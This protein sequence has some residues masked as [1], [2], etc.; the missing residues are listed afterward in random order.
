VDLTAFA[1]RALMLLLIVAAQ[2]GAAPAASA[3]N[4][5]V[6]EWLARLDELHLRRDDP[7]AR[8]EAQRVVSAAL[9]AAPADYGVLWRAARARL[10][11]S[12]LPTRSPEERSR[13]GTEA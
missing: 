4:P 12:D 8:S 7:A 10:T 6:A 3:G 13:L 11:E 2:A 5:S 1:P 9:A